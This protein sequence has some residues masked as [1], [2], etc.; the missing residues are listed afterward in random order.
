MSTT[1]IYNQNN[2]TPKVENLPQIF[3]FGEKK[4]RT[5]TDEDGE[6]WFV[7]K[8]VAE[9]LGYRAA[10]NAT[11]R[12]DE[13]KKGVYITQ[14]SG[15]Q[16]KLII[17]KE[18]GLYALIFASRKAKAKKFK[19]WVTSEMLSMIRK[20]GGYGQQIDL[21][22]TKQLHELLLSTSDKYGQLDAQSQ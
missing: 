1:R 6:L 5:V 2:Q 17:I 20:T 12:L 19:K 7:A 3:D 8:D 15:G 18:S 21:S 16:Q 10:S 14:T 9:I 11:I 13:D 22:N 4:V